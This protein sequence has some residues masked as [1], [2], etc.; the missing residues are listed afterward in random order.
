[1]Q[2]SVQQRTRTLTNGVYSVW[3]AWATTTE[4]P[5]YTNTDLSEYRLDSTLASIDLVDVTTLYGELT[6]LVKNDLDE[7]WAKKRIKGTEYADVYSKLIS[8]SLQLAVNGATKNAELLVDQPVKDAQKSLYIRQEAGFDDDL[9]RKMLDIQMN[10]WAMMFSS[11]LLTSKPAIIA[12]D[13]VTN[14]YNVMLDKAAPAA[15]KVPVV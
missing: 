14:L 11:G 9:R 7:Q 1:M 8:T 13:A 6:N 15:P 10:A 12:N 5:P 2:I 4:V 3:S